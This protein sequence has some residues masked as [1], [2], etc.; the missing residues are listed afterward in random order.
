MGRW[1][2]RKRSGG[3]NLAPITPDLPQMVSASIT[4]ANTA[5]VFYS[6]PVNASE[7]GGGDHESI[8]SHAITTNYI[9]NDDYSIDATFDDT[10]TGDT[11]LEWH[12]TAPPLKTPDE[13]PYT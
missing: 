11:S 13:I 4:G 3:G 6:A 8:S 7:F 1:A 9:Q 12:G 2:Q 5:R 10:I